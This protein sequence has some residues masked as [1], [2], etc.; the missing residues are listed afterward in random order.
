MI[1][2]SIET[3]DIIKV[4]LFLKGNTGLVIQGT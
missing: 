2:L 3:L 4:L 1:E